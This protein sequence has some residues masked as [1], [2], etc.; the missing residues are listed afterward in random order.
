MATFIP[1]LFL[2]FLKLLPDC[3]TAYD[4]VSSVERK[5]RVSNA[6]RG[7]CVDSVQL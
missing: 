6:L 1:V 5:E 7:V 4:D 3:Q 2:I